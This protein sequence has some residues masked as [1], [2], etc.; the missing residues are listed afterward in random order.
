MPPENR[1]MKH[2]HQERIVLEAMKAQNNPNGSFR[3]INQ[4]RV[5]PDKIQ[6]LTVAYVCSRKGFPVNKQEAL[7]QFMIPD[8]W[9]LCSWHREIGDIMMLVTY[10]WLKPSLASYTVVSQR[11]T[12]FTFAQNLKN[13]PIFGLSTF[14]EKLDNQISE[15]MSDRECLKVFSASS[16]TCSWPTSGP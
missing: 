3:V 14:G 8:W 6:N 11:L 15:W 4:F 5:V 2:L 10:K 1:P 16:K 13:V 12:H 9:Q 7:F